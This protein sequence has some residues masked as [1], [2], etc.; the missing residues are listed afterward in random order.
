MTLSAYRQQI[1]QTLGPIKSLT[2]HKKKDVLEHPHLPGLLRITLAPPVQLIQLSL[3]L[4]SIHGCLLRGFIHVRGTLTVLLVALGEYHKPLV[5]RRLHSEWSTPA[6]P[7]PE[8]KVKRGTL[9]ENVTL[10]YGCS[11]RVIHQA[12]ENEIPCQGL[13]VIHCFHHH[14][15][16]DTNA[17]LAMQENCAQCISRGSSD[18]E[19]EQPDCLCMAKALFLA[20]YYIG[21]GTADGC[22]MIIT[23]TC[24]D[25]N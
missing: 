5:K 21:Q 18:N 7:S 8:S 3:E 16:W 6:P 17:C 12:L 11:A 14:H 10:R 4:L 25:P 15:N 1:E 23:S 2:S 24:S 19:T 9:H 13:R 22:E 20:E